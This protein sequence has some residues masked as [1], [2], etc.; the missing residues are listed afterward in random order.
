MARRESSR[1]EGAEGAHGMVVRE[2]GKNGSW[3]RGR[4]SMSKYFTGPDAI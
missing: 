3:L 2:L 1:R 4:P